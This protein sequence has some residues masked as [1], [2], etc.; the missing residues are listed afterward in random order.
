MYTETIERIQRFKL[1]LRMGVPIFLLAGVLL[2][3]LLTQYMEHIPSNFIIIIVGLLAVS[4]YF[5][6]YLIYQ[7]FNE[8]ITDN[9]T[10]TFTPQYIKK[11]F[12][13]RKK[14]SVQTL[15]LFSID[16]ISDVNERFGMKNGDELLHTISKEIDSFFKSKGIKKLIISHYKGG[17]FIILLDGY[18]RDNRILFDLFST[19]IDSSKIN[20]IEIKSSGAVI[21]TE[22][23]EDFDKL[24]DR[25]FELKIDSQKRHEIIEN[26]KINLSKLENSIVE[27]IKRKRLSV[28]GQKISYKES[29]IVDISVKL[30]DEN[31]KFIHQKRFLPIITR[32][33]LRADYE[34]MKIEYILNEPKRPSN[35]YYALNIAAEVLRNTKFK[36]TLKT[37]LSDIKEPKLIIIIEEKEYFSNIKYFDNIIQEYR[38]LGIKI[39]LDGLGNNHTTQLYMKDLHVD[40]VRFDSSYGK[41]IQDIRYQNI[42]EGLNLTAQKMNLLTWIKLISDKESAKIAQDIGIDI[43]SGNYF[44]KIT[45]IQN[46]H[47]EEI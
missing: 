32:L 18:Q 37:L 39:V 7:G 38:T 9:I 46:L 29:F 28:M 8:R 47:K 42:I 30:I 19:K 1:A 17:I 21:D 14:K 26:D 33:G 15:I 40:M 36:N 2:F 24:L 5:Q 31:G 43:I 12:N 27:A 22:I 45:E 3:S 34:L 10:H 25:L 11:L 6:F 16:N 41:K 4:V 13:Q 35:Y 23:S 20:D 44:S